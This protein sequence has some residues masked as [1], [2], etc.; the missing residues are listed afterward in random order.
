MFGNIFF[1]CLFLFLICYA[2]VSIFYNVSDF[3]LRKYCKY[4]TKSFITIKLTHE[5]DSLDSDIRCALSKSLKERCA[6]LVVCD[7]LDF[8]ENTIVWRVTDSYEHV[9]VTTTED[10]V[11][12]LD[13]A[14]SVS[15]SL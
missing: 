9:V 7:G 10:V 6:L 1:D 4:P 5:S 2:L 12:K 15:V 11:Q 13:T 8:Q 14:A 3:L